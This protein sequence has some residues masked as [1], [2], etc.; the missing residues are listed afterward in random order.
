[1]E[2]RKQKANGW[3]IRLNEEIRNSR[4]GVFVTLTFSNDSIKELNEEIDKE[5]TGYDR[6]N[7]IATLAIRRMLERYR[8]KYKTSVK[9]WLI[10]EL[11]HKGTENI[12]INGI[13]F[14]NS[15]REGKRTV[16]KEDIIKQAWQYGWVYCGYSMGEK[17]VNY[18]VKYMMKPDNDHKGFMPKIHTS[19]GI[20]ANWEKRYDARLN[21]YNT[22]ADKTDETYKFRNGT[23]SALPIYYRNKI[24]N[25][26]IREILWLVLS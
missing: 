13:I 24:Y 15:R 17:A 26:D 12:H 25:E 6:D 10:T 19:P 8:K 14:V 16:L 21:T 3:K 18:V 7:A 23:K 1:M 5:I 2:C 20:G 4:N 22:K 11:G 9:H